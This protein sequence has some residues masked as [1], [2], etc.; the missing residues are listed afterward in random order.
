MRV[1]HPIASA[2][3]VPT[4]LLAI[5]ALLAAA[6][7]AASFLVVPDDVPGIGGPIALEAEGANVMADVVTCGDDISE[8]DDVH[9]AANQRE[10]DELRKGEPLENVQPGAGAGAAS[11]F[12]CVQ[13]RKVD[14]CEH[15]R[16]HRSP[17]MWVVSMRS[18]R[19]GSWYDTGSGHMSTVT[20][21]W[22]AVVEMLSLWAET[23]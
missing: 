6:V 12:E 2:I 20:W 22:H 5:I 16:L 3:L 7:I 14:S 8:T 19:R 1:T 17:T 10:L 11:E 15:S 9:I 4:M 13:V 21:W 23:L 18:E